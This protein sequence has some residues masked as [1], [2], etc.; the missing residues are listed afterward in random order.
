MAPDGHELVVRTYRRGCGY[1]RGKQLPPLVRKNKWLMFCWGFLG[2]NA[3]VESGHLFH[4]KCLDGYLIY[5]Y[6][7]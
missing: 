5:F 6:L 2:V 7:F 3:E 4:F 1:P